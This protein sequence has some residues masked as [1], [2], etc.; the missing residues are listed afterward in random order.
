MTQTTEPTAERIRAK[1]YAQLHGEFF[2]L[3]TAN[4]EV[5]RVANSIAAEID[6]LRAEVE[7]LR[8]AAEA[9]EARFEYNRRSAEFGPWTEEHKKLSAEYNTKGDIADALLY[10]ARE[11]AKGQK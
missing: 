1:I 7:R 9:W 8:P 3:E 2:S 4:E 10:A 5:T 6:A 11:A